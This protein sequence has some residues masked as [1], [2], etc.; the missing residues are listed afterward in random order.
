MSKYIPYIKKLTFSNN[1]IDNNFDVIESGYENQPLF[2]LGYHYW[3][4][5]VREK[6]N[7]GELQK[8]KFF[9][10]VNQ[11]E[12]NIPDHNEDL[13]SI[14]S[15]EF[16]LDKDTNIISRD[17]YKLWEIL[18]Y[19]NLA[20]DK[21]FNSVSLSENGGFLQC[22]HYFRNKY[23]N[24][25]GD[26]YCYQGTASKEMSECLKDSIKNNK[27]L[28]LK[29]DPS[30][31]LNNT[32]YLSNVASVEK[33][34]KDNK[35]S[36]VNLITAN[37]IIDYNKDSNSEHQLYKILLG[38]ILTALIIQK[39]KGNFIL[40]IEDCFT[41]VTIKLL[42][43]LYD[44]Y[45]ETFIC[46]PLFS[47]SF[48]NEKYIIC[49]SFKLKDSAKTNLIKKLKTLLDNMNNI[50]EN[51]KFISDIITTYNVNEN[52]MDYIATINLDL[53]GNEHL[54]INKIIDYKKNKNYFGEQ[55]HK[56]RDKQIEASKWW[57]ETFIKS[58]LTEFN[59]IRKE[60]VT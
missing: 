60:L 58:K 44:C 23:I 14:I 20:D 48:N 21:K 18:I 5:Q 4:E 35:L 15:S 54:N 56:F 45:D 51:N 11:F 46:K 49:K 32:N 17:L 37:G 53:V 34:I 24:S 29:D 26:I 47:R 9:L 22:I 43:I 42:N 55:Y 39:D 16:N 27:L 7:D 1:I 57:N 25:K 19:F 38:E 40:R 8:R 36:N 3:T 41:K 33:L 10:I 52:D 28:K 50:T 6:M 13:D 30:E 2:S 31:Q 12:S 59:T